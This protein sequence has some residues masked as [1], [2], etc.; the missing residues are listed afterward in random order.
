MRRGARQR[1]LTVSDSRHQISVRMDPDDRLVAAVGGAA[2]YLADAAGLATE[3]ILQF[4][5]SVVSACQ[6]C[7]HC[8]SSDAPCGITLRR[9]PDRLEVEVA[10]PGAE[11]PAGQGPSWAGIDE[12]RC[13]SREH[14]GVLRLT[15]YVPPNSPED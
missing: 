1:P 5:A 3:A 15:K 2:R 9:S 13:E 7:F 14:A 4:Q 8:H 10:V 12:V 11:P 6:H